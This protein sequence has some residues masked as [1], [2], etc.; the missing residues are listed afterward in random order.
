MVDKQ[1][2]DFYADANK[3]LDELLRGSPDYFRHAREPI[4]TVLTPML[5]KL[6]SDQVEVSLRILNVLR[7]SGF[8]VCYLPGEIVGMTSDNH[9]FYSGSGNLPIYYMQ[10]HDEVLSMVR[11][12][13]AKERG[14]QTGQLGLPTDEVESQSITDLRSL[15][16][17]L[18]SLKQ[19][20]TE[21]GVL[22]PHIKTD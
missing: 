12:A 10:P 13:L 7:P 8:A 11:V 6:T 2:N 17:A 1:A 22:P 18:E 20:T 19:T 5:P 14:A 9:V 21:S 16:S 4:L 3:R 15:E